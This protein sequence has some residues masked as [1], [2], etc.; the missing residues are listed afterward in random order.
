M[1]LDE[2]FL[3]AL[4]HDLDAPDV[5]GLLLT[6]SYVR[7]EATP[8]SDVDVLRFLKETP[9]AE[10]GGYMLRV[11]EHKLISITNT[12]V[13]DKLEQLT[14]PERCFYAV[15]GIRQARILLDKPGELTKLKQA[16]EDFK[17]E[18]IASAA[19]YYSSRL[20][21]GTA[22]G[23]YKIMG[24]FVRND[25]SAVAA[26]ALEIEWCLGMVMAVHKRLLLPTE[27]V[28]FRGVIQACG[29]DSEWSKAFRLCAGFELPRNGEEVMIARGRAGLRLYLLTE[30]ELRP[31][32]KE[33]HQ[34][35][36]QKTI[37]AIKG[38]L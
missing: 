37:E 13:Q 28:F 35:V 6:G 30:S 24:G 10:D 31:I 34:A 17:W 22:E 11:F 12:S 9:K 27:N 1:P 20:L 14:K 23:A 7:G 19:D 15:E 29:E 5:V 3:S 26:G 32:I 16:A 4:I 36:I 38:I 8:Y 21:S 25:W 18:A 2:S 33:E